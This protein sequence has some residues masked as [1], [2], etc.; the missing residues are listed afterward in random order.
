[1]RKLSSM[2]RLAYKRLMDGAERKELKNYY[3]ASME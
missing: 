3:P 2:V 1:M